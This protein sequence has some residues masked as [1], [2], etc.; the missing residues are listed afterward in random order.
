M[1]KFDYTDTIRYLRR[2][3]YYPLNV[4]KGNN[5]LQPND[6]TAFLIWN[7]PAVKT[8]PF[9]TPHCEKFCYAT[10]AEKLYT[11]CLPSRMNNLEEAKKDDF[12][13]N[14]ILTIMIKYKGMRQNKLVV[15]IHES[16]DFFNKAYVAQWLTV[17]Q[18]FEKNDDITFIAYTKS[19]P[20]FDGVQLPKNFSLRASVW[21]DTKREH[22]QTI[23]RNDWMIYTATNEI[24]KVPTHAQ[25]R[26]SDCA[27]CN[28]CWASKVK[29][30]VCEIH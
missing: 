18:A 14:M 11:T 28:K 21:D 16:G 3:G 25:C 4:S 7:L 2:S 10:K 27:T 5:K 20:Y 22:L 26:C 8:C 23:W 24:D 29:E 13:V 17:M 19:F 15:R 30:I 12:A 1:K 9:R 6:D